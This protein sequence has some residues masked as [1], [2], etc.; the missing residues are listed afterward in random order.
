MK[1]YKITYYIDVPDALPP[2][3]QKALAMKKYNVPVLIE[4]IIRHNAERI[5]RESE[6][7]KFL[8]PLAKVKSTSPIRLMGN[9][10]ENFGTA[11][12]SLRE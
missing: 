1:S 8:G 11:T 5:A 3:A 9:H 10:G 7:L 12:I 6:R 2:E 4:N